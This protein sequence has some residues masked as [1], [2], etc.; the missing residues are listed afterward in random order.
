M[1]RVLSE[2][3]LL[4]FSREGSFDEEDYLPIQLLLVVMMQGLFNTMSQQSYELL[5]REINSLLGSI[6][7][8]KLTWYKRAKGAS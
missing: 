3:S 7:Q 1:K 8:D 2:R 6:A 4:R 5:Y